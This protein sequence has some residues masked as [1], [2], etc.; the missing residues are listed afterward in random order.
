MLMRAI[1][2][3]QVSSSR[4][5]EAFYCEKLG[6]TMQFATRPFG[7]DDPCYMGF[8]RDEAYIHVSSFPGDGKLGSAVMVQVDD[9][10]V[11]YRELATKGL[12]IDPTPVDQ[13]WG[14]REMYVHDE[15]GNSIR[16]FCPME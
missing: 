3:L 16:F 6:F 13:S 15:D 9:V 11:L 14:N 5:A 2:V 4:R 10:D 1:P 8:L 12:R 7:T